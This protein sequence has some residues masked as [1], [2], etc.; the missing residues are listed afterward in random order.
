M[1]KTKPKYITPIVRGS[2]LIQSEDALLANSG[3]TPP[4]SLTMDYTIQGQTV[5]SYFEE[6]D[7]GNAWE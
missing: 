5:E 6:D 3:I 1:F 2:V 4:P 7:L